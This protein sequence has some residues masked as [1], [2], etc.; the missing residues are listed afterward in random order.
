M[1]RSMADIATAALE[2]GPYAPG[3]T[4]GGVRSVDLDAGP[5][6]ADLWTDDDLGFVL[7][8]HRRRDGFPATELYWS[9]PGPD[10]RWTRAE[11]LSGGAYAWDRARDPWW[12]PGPDDAAFTVLSSSESLLLTGRGGFEGEEEG[13]E[14]VGFSELLVGARVDRLRVERYG[15]GRASSYTAHSVLEKPLLSPL[16]LVAVRPGERVRLSAVDRDGT[17]GEGLELLPPEG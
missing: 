12:E 10:G 6:V 8:L 3:G 13:A 7:L 1:R 5:V 9:T 16:V 17:A 14:L 4:P 15:L 11:H 2:R